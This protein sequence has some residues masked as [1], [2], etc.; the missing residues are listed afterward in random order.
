M[1]GLLMI[2]FFSP[3]D[4]NTLRSGNLQ[5]RTTLYRCSPRRIL[6][7]VC[8]PN[9]VARSGEK[10]VPPPVPQRRYCRC[11]NIGSWREAALD[12]MV[13]NSHL[14]SFVNSCRMWT[15]V[16]YIFIHILAL[17][18]AGLTCPDLTSCALHGLPR[19]GIRERSHEKK[20]IAKS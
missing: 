18:R 9:I 20:Y 16:V 14:D 5:P 13:W 6:S 4:G 17:C 3:A 15:A 19:H 10:K 1:C 12:E 7:V 2:F 8:M 11:T